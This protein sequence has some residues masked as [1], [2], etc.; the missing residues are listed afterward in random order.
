[1]R[2]KPAK[3][4]PHALPGCVIIPVPNNLGDT[5]TWLDSVNPDTVIFSNG[6]DLNLEVARDQSERQVMQW[7]L[8]HGI[9]LLGVCRGLQFVNCFFGA[10]L[11][12]DL[13]GEAGVNHVDCGHDVVL[14]HP[15][16][17]SMVEC[18]P[19]QARVNSYH[20]HG[21]L[22]ADLAPG[23]TAFATTVDGAVEGLVHDE[24]PVLAVQWHPERA[25]T[26]QVFGETL[27][28]KFMLEGK[29]W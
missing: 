16:F 5:K 4:K 26:D 23:L 8:V 10:G 27:V 11:T 18:V 14:S 12:L 2:R 25:G 24:K 9:T 1:M 22:A 7:A 21:V 13:S 15:V 17:S 29:F 28:R 6:N 19:A 20:N 3:R